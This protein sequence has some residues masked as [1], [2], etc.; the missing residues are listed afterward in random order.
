MFDPGDSPFAWGG[1]L[2]ATGMVRR[3]RYAAQAAYR[4]PAPSKGAQRGHSPPTAYFVLATPTNDRP[5][6]GIGL[7]STR[8]ALS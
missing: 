4:V 2:A 8:L 1:Q 7:K 5:V 6:S 3:G